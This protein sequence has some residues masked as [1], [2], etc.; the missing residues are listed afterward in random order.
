[1]MIKAGSALMIPRASTTVNDV[2]SQVAD[3][4]QISFTPEI[5]NR[6]TIVRAGKRGETVAA[7]AARYKVS[8]SD[9]ADWNDVKSSSHFKSG[10]RVVMYLPVRLSAAS[11]AGNS[12]APR[13]AQPVAQATSSKRG[14]ASAKSSAGKSA[15]A[16]TAKTAT[17]S[18]KSS[19]GSA[20]A[21]SSAK[22]KR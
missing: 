16:S 21:S 2:P 20:A 8:A 10:E 14:A 9:V 5:V 15:K 13:Q 1:M 3:N 18:S 4:G 11:Y 6:R 12:A 17:T 19:K 22:R 7:I